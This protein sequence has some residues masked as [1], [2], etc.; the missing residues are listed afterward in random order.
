MNETRPSSAPT[1]QVVL[2]HHGEA[3]RVAAAMPTVERLRDAMATF[4]TVQIR[5]IWRQAPLVPVPPSELASRRL[6]QWRTERRWAHH[7]GVSARWLLS[8]GLLGVRLLQLLDPR[9]RA[10]AGRQAAIELALTGK[11]EL[12][13]RHAYEDGTDLLVV[14]EDDARWRDDSGERVR[15]LMEAAAST[16]RLEDAFIDL[17]GGIST[18]TLRTGGVRDVGPD[19]T[20]VLSRASTN[21]TCGYLLGRK[22]IE[23]LAGLTV[24]QPAS[25]RLPAD[26]LINS[27]F[28]S[29][30]KDPASLRVRCLHS[31]PHALDHGSF[32]GSVAS[33]IRVARARG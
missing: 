12:A 2:I 3:S 26:W 18:K 20:A 25:A 33:S 9:H 28:M 11:H 23:E 10:A 5:E 4:G 17:A 24:R 8:T 13:W 19:G 29:L 15:N 14:V 22:L 6:R 1:V 31:V 16:G 32:T 21:T 7:L 30:A 27:C